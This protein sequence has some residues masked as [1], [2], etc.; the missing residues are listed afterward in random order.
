M[1]NLFVEFGFQPLNMSKMANFG[2]VAKGG[3]KKN[4]QKWP[5]FWSNFGRLKK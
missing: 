2:K 4:F 3:P 5:I 1:I